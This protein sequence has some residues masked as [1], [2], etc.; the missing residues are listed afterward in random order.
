MTVYVYTD[1]GIAPGRANSV[2]EGGYGAVAARPG[3]GGALVE[4]AR[5]AGHRLGEAT[6]QQME[7]VAA[8]AGIALAA[9][10]A[11]PG[12]AV[13]VRS[14]SA[15]VV[16]CLLDG[17]WLRWMARAPAWT[18]SAGRP[19]ENRELWREL[20]GACA[21]THRALAAKLGPSPWRRLGPEDGDVAVRSLRGGAEA[22]F[23]KVRGHAG[24]PLNEAADRLATEGKYGRTLLVL[25]GAG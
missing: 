16:N 22:A 8:R 9:R 18:N 6:N 3:P 19:V 21:G 11:L 17:W 5:E 13:V 4:L 14:D 10:V 1:G 24:D 20:L 7:I 2:G 23:E 12:E 25:H 15:Y